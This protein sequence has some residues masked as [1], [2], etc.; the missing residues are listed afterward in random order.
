LA[1]ANIST[2]QYTGYNML[3]HCGAAIHSLADEAA[4]VDGSGAPF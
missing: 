3:I 1:L 2:W 4:A